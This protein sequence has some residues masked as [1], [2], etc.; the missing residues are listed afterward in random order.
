MQAEKLTQASL[1]LEKE[2]A[3]ALIIAAKRERKL[4][5]E[6]IAQAISM[7]PV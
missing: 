1:T 4:T 7:S 2:D 3:T 5:W 6:E